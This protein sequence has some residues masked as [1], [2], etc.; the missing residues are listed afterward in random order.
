MIYTLETLCEALEL[1]GHVIKQGHKQVICEKCNMCFCLWWTNRT[2][3][4]SKNGELVW[5][6]LE[7]TLTCNEL[8]IKNIIE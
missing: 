2:V 5:H 8:V 7:T 1:R 6:R 3:L 4:F